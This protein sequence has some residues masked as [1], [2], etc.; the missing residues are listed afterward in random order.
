MQRQNFQRWEAIA[1]VA[2]VAA[3]VVAQVVAGEPSPSWLPMDPYG[4]ALKGC[5]GTLHYFF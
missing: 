2:V 3:A 5:D 4:E 1:V